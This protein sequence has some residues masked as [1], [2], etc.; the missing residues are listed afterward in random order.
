[1]VEI[2]DELQKQAEKIAK[3]KEQ[4]QENK[5][6][7]NNVSIS[8]QALQMMIELVSGIIVGASIGYILDEIFDF[9]F[10]CLLIFTIFGGMAGLMNMIR[11]TYKIKETK[12]ETKRV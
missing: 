1:M 4:L 11:Y 3:I 9:K 6:I 2:S 5:K 10:I 7:E 12:E 8:S